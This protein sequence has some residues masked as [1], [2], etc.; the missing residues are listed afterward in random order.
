MRESIV[1]NYVSKSSN[2]GDDLAQEVF[3]S[4]RRLRVLRWGPDNLPFLTYFVP[5]IFGTAALSILLPSEA[6]L[7]FAYLLVPFGLLSLRIDPQDLWGWLL[8]V[9]V[10]TLLGT[11]SVMT[12]ELLA[13]FLMG[14]PA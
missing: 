10:W 14:N 13:Q 6:F 4:A 8:H 9:T 1:I 3:A 7:I 5:A 11:Y 12:F 2:T